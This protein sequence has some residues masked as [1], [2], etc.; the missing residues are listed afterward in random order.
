MRHDSA[1][2]RTVN[3]DG[4]AA[5]VATRMISLLLT[6]HAA[7]PA[8]HRRLAY[9]RYDGAACLDPALRDRSRD[10]IVGALS[11]DTGENDA[12][13]SCKGILL[14]GVLGTGF[15]VLLTVFLRALLSG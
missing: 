3:N 5:G 6:R 14:A 15:W 4:S 10:M 7:F 8:C 13:R 11:M 2:C 12:L 1:P 9:A